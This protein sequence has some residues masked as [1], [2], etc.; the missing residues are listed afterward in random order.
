MSSMLVSY[1]FD[2]VRYI[3]KIHDNCKGLKIPDV[4]F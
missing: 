2:I 3:E 4:K 1:F